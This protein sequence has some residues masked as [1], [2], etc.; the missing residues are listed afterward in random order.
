MKEDAKAT[1]QIGIIFTMAFWDRFIKHT[2]HGGSKNSNSKLIR[3][4][5][6]F[7]VMAH[8]NTYMQKI[9]QK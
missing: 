8:C 9:F 4:D 2:H 7:H 1:E 3:A 6:Y 5:S